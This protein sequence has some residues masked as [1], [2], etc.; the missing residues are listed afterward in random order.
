VSY[1]GFLAGAGDSWCLK[2][3]GS[4]DIAAALNAHVFH[5]PTGRMGRLI[6]ELGTV[7]EILPDGA[8]NNGLFGALLYWDDIRRYFPRLTAARVKRCLERLDEIESDLALARPRVEDAALVKD[9]LRNA[10]AMCRLGLDRASAITGR[11]TGG[12]ASRA[13]LRRRI[14]DEHRRLWL[15]RNRPGGLA[16]S[17]GNLGKAFRKM[18]KSYR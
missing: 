9:E 7:Q 3:N 16:E 18:E 15:S 10:I 5:D 14:A 1:P 17:V 8:S 2:T 6:M 13:S 11:R 4:V 12:R